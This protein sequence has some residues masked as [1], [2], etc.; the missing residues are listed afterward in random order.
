MI[1]HAYPQRLGRKAAGLGG[2]RDTA[3]ARL[4]QHRPGRILGHGVA[5]PH[6]H[7]QDI[8]A[9]RIYLQGHPVRHRGQSALCW[10]YLLGKRGGGQKRED[11]ESG[12][13]TAMT[14]SRWHTAPSA[15]TNAGI[16]S[17]GTI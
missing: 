2:Y 4:W 16:V 3:G 15:S 8:V 13:F 10:C 7:A 1:I 5:L 9:Q 12:G 11:E 14:C 17:S 6:T